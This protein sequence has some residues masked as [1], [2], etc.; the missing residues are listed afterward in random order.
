MEFDK[1]RWYPAHRNSDQNCTQNS[2]R[3]GGGLGVVGVNRVVGVRGGGGG[4]RG[5]GGTLGSGWGA[6]GGGV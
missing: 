5:G 3:G 1:T 6:R 4:L 2:A